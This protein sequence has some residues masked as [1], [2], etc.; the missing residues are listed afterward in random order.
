[1]IVS[2]ADVQLT[3]AKTNLIRARAA[4]HTTKLTSVASLA[5]QAVASADEARQFAEGRLAESLFRREAMV[6]ILAII[7]INVFAL[8]LIR[9]RLDHSYEAPSK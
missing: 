4:V 9:R 6:V 5:D 7:V 2:D 3:E 8:I 1:M